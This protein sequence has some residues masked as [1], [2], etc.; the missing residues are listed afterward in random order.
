MKKKCTMCGMIRAQKDMVLL[1]SGDFICFSCW[2]TI[3]KERREK[4]QN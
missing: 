1:E 4:P 2:N 3:L